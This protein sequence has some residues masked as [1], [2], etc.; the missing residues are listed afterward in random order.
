MKGVKPRIP[1]QMKH[2]YSSFAINVKW[3]V[4]TQK[5]TSLALLAQDKQTRK[6]AVRTS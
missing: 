3:K 6:K 2:I 5:F 1:E 4:K